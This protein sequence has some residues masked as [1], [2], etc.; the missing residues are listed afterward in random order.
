M[1]FTPPYLKTGDRIGVIAPA[2]HV[3]YDDIRPGL[4][5]LSR[6]WRLRV[7]EGASVQSTYFQFAGTDQERLSELQEMLDDPEIKAILAVR[8]GYGCSRIIDSLNF[9]KF[10]ESPKWVVGF[11]DVTVI[12]SHLSG[13]GYAGIH[14]PMVRHLCADGGEAALESLR[15]AL[16][17]EPLHHETPAHPLNRTGQTEA[18]MTGGN[19]CL[20]AHLTGSVSEPDTEGRILFIEDIG[21][22]HYNLDRMMLQLKRAGKLKDLAGLVVGQFTDLKDSPSRF[23]KS[24]CE[25]VRE[26]TDQY[27]YP[28][29]FDFPAGHVADN[30][31][32]VFGVKAMLNVGTDKAHLAFRTG[33]PVQ[34]GL[35]VQ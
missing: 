35:P 22:P 9:G 3:P 8:G 25:I 16:F 12:L 15:K 31:A 13:L 28:I 4:E 23:G 5:L 6:D 27:S 21:E 33:T 11:S 29:L 34:E 32:L 1:L 7:S 19:L 2:G 20:L 10:R 17:G 14:G 24:A 18:V 26:H 30:R